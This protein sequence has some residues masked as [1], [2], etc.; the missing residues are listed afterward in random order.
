MKGQIFLPVR[1]LSC[2]ALWMTL[3]HHQG[4]S[5][6]NLSNTLFFPQ[7]KKGVH[8]NGKG[9]RKQGLALT[10]AVYLFRAV[11]D[12]LGW[13]QYFF[14]PSGSHVLVAAPYYPNILIPSLRASRGTGDSGL[15][16]EMGCKADFYNCQ[17]QVEATL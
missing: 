2:L 10:S 12:F 9:Y 4:S 7:C 16:V 14:F 6:L 1:G 17:M 11:Y 5:S 13:Q 3:E 8:V 15:T